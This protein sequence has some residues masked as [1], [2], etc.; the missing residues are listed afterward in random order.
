MNIICDNLDHVKKDIHAIAIKNGFSEDKMTLVAVSKKK[1]VEEIRFA[2]DHGQ[3]HFGENY[4]QDLVQKQ[5]VFLGTQI[6][7]HFIGHLQRNKA[8]LL[9]GATHL[10]HTL[11]NIKLAQTIDKLCQERN[12]IQNCLIQVNVSN[13]T[14]KHG[15]HA[16]ELISFVNQLNDLK[17]IHLIGLM[18][19]GSNTNE[20]TL[21]RREYRHLRELLHE[22]N[23]RHIYKHELTE[24]SMGMSHDYQIAIEEGATIVR[25]GTGIFGERL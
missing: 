17:Q 21:I 14:S 9:V 15:C 4:I 2:L 12:T 5:A 20:E 13:E 24:L 19:I 3:V 7:W 23:E 18:T 10:F 25:V 8:K 1:T 16:S 6:K 22:V 11:D